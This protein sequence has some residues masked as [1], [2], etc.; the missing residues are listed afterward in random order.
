MPLS[1]SPVPRYPDDER[2]RRIEGS[3]W[4]SLVITE[5]GTVAANTLQ[6]MFATREAFARAVRDAAPRFRFKPARRNG[7]LISK[8]IVV[9]FVF[10]LTQPGEAWPSSVRHQPNDRCS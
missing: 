4:A 3:V 1:D 7:V 10:Q 6:V 5:R 2:G 9:P 8:R